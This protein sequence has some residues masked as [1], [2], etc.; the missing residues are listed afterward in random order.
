MTALNPPRFNSVVVGWSLFCLAGIAVG[1][2]MV[3][4]SLSA[5]AGDAVRE[6]W[7][8]GGAVTISIAILSFLVVIGWHLYAQ[9]TVEIGRQSLQ[10]RRWSEVWRGQSGTLFDLRRVQAVAFVVRSGGAKLDV[11]EEGCTSSTTAAS[12][13]LGGRRDATELAWGAVFGI[14]GPVAD[15]IPISALRSLAF[16]E[17]TVGFTRGLLTS[18]FLTAGQ[19]VVS[20]DPYYLASQRQ[21]SRSSKP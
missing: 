20:M 19:G 21:G 9:R 11:Q 2:V 16:R 6:S 8:V 4:S 5:G 7:L 18:T 14:A 17:T 3:A 13:G 15:A 12:M 1:S 10:V